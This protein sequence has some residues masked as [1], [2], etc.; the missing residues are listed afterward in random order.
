MRI[1]LL[2]NHPQRTVTGQYDHKL[3]NIVQDMIINHVIWEDISHTFIEIPKSDGKNMALLYL[4]V[5]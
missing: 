2:F 4:K 5:L 1:S 3:S